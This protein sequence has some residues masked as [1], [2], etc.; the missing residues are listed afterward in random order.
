MLFLS[1]RRNWKVTSRHEDLVFTWTMSLTFPTSWVLSMFLKGLHPVKADG[2]PDRY[3]QAL[4][5]VMWAQGLETIKWQF[6]ETFTCKRARNIKA[7]FSFPPKAS[8]FLLPAQF[9][10]A[11]YPC[12][13][14]LVSCPSYCLVGLPTLIL[15]PR[16]NEH[17]IVKCIF[18]CSAFP[19]NTS[20]TQLS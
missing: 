15:S 6:S 11:I 3:F 16:S 19:Q 17:T 12:S 14:F 5:V 4:V 18:P 8:S 1:E 20:G 2:W 7:C 10:L 13:G 9:F